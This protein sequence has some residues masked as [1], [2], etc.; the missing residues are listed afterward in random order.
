MVVINC[1]KKGT[2]DNSKESIPLPRVLWNLLGTP[3]NVA[4]RPGASIQV[5]APRDAIWYLIWQVTPSE[6]APR[7]GLDDSPWLK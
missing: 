6:L 3:W 7:P 1:L 2:P 5:L 4:S